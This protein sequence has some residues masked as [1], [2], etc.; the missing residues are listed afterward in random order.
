MILARRV[1]APGRVNLIGDHTDYNQGVALPV[2]I[3]L[4]TTAEF[5]PNG[6]SLLTFFST[7]YPQGISLRRDLP[8]DPSVLST[9]EPP[10]AR[11]VGAVIA[12]VGV[13]SGGIGRIETTIPIGAG[14]S[15]SASLMVALAGVLGATGSARTIARLCQQAENFSGV[16]VGIMDPLVSAG[17][18]AGHG[19]LIDF[20]DLSTTYVP[21]P[22]DAQLVVVDSG[23]PR[24]LRFT[25]YAARVAECEAAA[26]IIGPLG[27][28]DDAD[29]A[30]LRDKRLHRRAHH[31]VSECARVRQVAAALA[32]GDLEAAGSRLVESHRSLAD[33]FE[34][35]TPE[36]DA[37]VDHLC[38][39]DGV[40]GARVTGA[41]F[42]GSVVALCR[43][44]AVD[45]RAVPAGARIVVPSDG[46]VADADRGNSEVGQLSAAP[47]G[48]LGA[49]AGAD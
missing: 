12:I 24:T 13:E 30:G 9:L 4:G 22:E 43:P 39:L 21:I 11:L 40:Y 20:S 8:L 27:L 5:T 25:E 38:S 10:W 7:H 6:S 15:S 49:V 35:S 31:V 17:G 23:V 2:A 47:A 41:G 18:R 3:D 14:L 29:L 34:V 19:M 1:T 16:P 44:G 32:D 48:S 37:L 42:G 46:T 26:S 45:V 36:V 33:D 28:A